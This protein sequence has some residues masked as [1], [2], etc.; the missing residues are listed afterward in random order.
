LLLSLLLSRLPSRS[1]L[2]GGEP[3]LTSSDLVIF[4]RHAGHAAPVVSALGGE[5]MDVR[6]SCRSPAA[7][8]RDSSAGAAPR[9]RELPLGLSTDCRRIEGTRVRRLGGWKTRCWLMQASRLVVG[10]ALRAV[11]HFTL[12]SLDMAPSFSSPSRQHRVLSAQNER[13]CESDHL[14]P[15]IRTSRLNWLTYVDW[16]RFAPSR[17]SPTAGKWPMAMS[18]SSRRLTT[19]REQ[20]SARRDCGQ[21][22]S[23]ATPRGRVRS[24]R[25]P[26]AAAPRAGTPAACRPP[27]STGTGS[28]P[29]RFWAGESRGHT[30]SAVGIDG[31][32]PQIPSTKAQSLQ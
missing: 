8:Y 7:A 19:G 16:A 11:G 21:M 9:A 14:Q 25:S 18:P 23:P 3:A 26:V 5:A 1:P 13:R 4:H 20:R 2:G 12:K 30:Y 32:P 17:M 24:R 31:I 6:M 15:G 27:A 28:T 22:A 10:W 29:H